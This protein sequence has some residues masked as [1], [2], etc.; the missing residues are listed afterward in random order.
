MLSKYIKSAMQQ[1][2]YEM[3]DNGTFYGE[4]SE[5]RGVW[6]NE[7][8]LEVCRDELQSVLEDWMLARISDCLALP[9]LDGVMSSAIE[10]NSRL[11]ATLASF[12]LEDRESVG[13]GLHCW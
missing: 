12:A 13:N 2:T 4:I 8:K 3:L 7:D 11:S 6:A 5:C 10:G 1:A 9:V